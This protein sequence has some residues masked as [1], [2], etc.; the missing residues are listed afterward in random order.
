[1]LPKVARKNRKFLIGISE[2]QLFQGVWGTVTAFPRPC[3]VV[4]QEH[5]SVYYRIQDVVLDGL[6]QYDPAK[7]FIR[8]SA[9][10]L[11]PRS[12]L[13]VSQ[14]SRPIYGIFRKLEA[15]SARLEF[16]KP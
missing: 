14:T 4:S 3:L 5:L 16:F 15:L 10:P 6:T 1:M 13:N 7:L 2:Y 11:A 8:L 12:S 9:F